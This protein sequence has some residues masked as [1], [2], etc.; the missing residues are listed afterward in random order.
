M[1]YRGRFRGGQRSQNRRGFRSSPVVTES[2]LSGVPDHFKGLFRFIITGDFPAV[3]IS[4]AN[5]SPY[6]TELVTVLK[7]KSSEFLREEKLKLGLRCLSFCAR[8]MGR[9]TVTKVGDSLVEDHPYEALGA[10]KLAGNR[11]RMVEVG[12]SLFEK[13]VYAVVVPYY[14]LAFAKDRLHM[15]AEFFLKNNST[16]KAREIYHFMGETPQNLRGLAK[17]LSEDMSHDSAF[18]LVDRFGTD[19]DMAYLGNVL[20]KK[21]LPGP[22]LKC[23]RK[24]SDAKGIAKAAKA[25]ARTGRWGEVFPVLESGEL[26]AEELDRKTL[27][28]MGKSFLAA[29]QLDDAETVFRLSEDSSSIIALAKVVAPKDPDKAM[30]LI[31]EAGGNANAYAL[32]GRLFLKSKRFHEAI[33]AYLKAGFRLSDN[34]VK[35]AVDQYFSHMRDSVE[36]L[37]GQPMIKELEEFIESLVELGISRKK[38]SRKVLDKIFYGRPHTS[39]KTNMDVA[40]IFGDAEALKRARKAIRESVHYNAYDRYFLALQSKNY[41]TIAI[42]NARF[43]H[44]SLA[45]SAWRKL[46]PKAR[47][48]VGLEIARILLERDFYTRPG[49]SAKPEAALKIYLELGEKSKAADLVRTHMSGDID[50]AVALARKSKLPKAMDMVADQLLESGDHERAREFYRI[51]RN[52]EGKRKV[53]HG[54]I[55]SGKLGSAIYIFNGIQA[56]LGSADFEALGRAFLEQEELGKARSYF[57]R[58]GKEL[59]AE[60]LVAVGDRIMKRGSEDHLHRARVYYRLAGEKAKIGELGDAFMVKNMVFT[61]A[62]CYDEAGVPERKFDL[63]FYETDLK[64]E[65]A[66]RVFTHS[67]APREKILALGELALERGVLGIAAEAYQLAG[68]PVPPG[69]LVESGDAIASEGPSPRA[70]LAYIL[71]GDVT[72][73]KE[74]LEGQA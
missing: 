17:K 33:D 41:W 27:V 44:P 74:A 26:P 71:A 42:E 29:E 38:E 37:W 58:T 30:E 63:E 68:E 67:K 5:E 2:Q 31:E 8:E 6:K 16:E 20:L 14:K 24:A 25:L 12:D 53:A 9:E 3:D 40:F 22:A 34:V 7:T 70:L 52:L 51:T 18:W 43:S 46:E 64:L 54:Y 56:H 48:E 62:G 65:A 4:L 1:S 11:K 15:A 55:Q 10:Y 32:C 72:K 61:A 57:S 69:L 35:G 66:L 73:I 19:E 23:F 59:P 13:G 49:R 60:M 45:I 36:K 47:K 28:K 50:L 21:K 39:A